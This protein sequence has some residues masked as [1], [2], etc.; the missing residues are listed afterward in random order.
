MIDESGV[1]LELTK[2]EALVLF[3]FLWRFTEGKR[4]VI[5]DQAEQRVLWDLLAMLEPILVEPFKRNYPELVQKA[6][7]DVRDSTE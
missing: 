5:E 1:T 4:L 7:D 2:A 6:R 3:D